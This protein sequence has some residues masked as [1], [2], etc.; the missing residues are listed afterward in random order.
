MAIA[1]GFKQVGENA[2]KFSLV[3]D[4]KTLKEIKENL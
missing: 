3:H 4:P 2:D 1:T